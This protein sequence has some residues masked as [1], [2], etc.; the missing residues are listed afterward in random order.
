MPVTRE[1]VHLTRVEFASVVATERTE[2]T[3][4][5]IHDAAGVSADVELTSGDDTC[6]V[7]RLVTDATASL[8]G[9]PIASE[10]DVPAMLDLDEHRP[11]RDLALATAL[12]ALRTGASIIQAVKCGVSLTV[13]L[14]GQ[15][16]DS[17]PLYAN[18]NRGL[19]ATPRT[20]SDFAA[21]AERAVRGGF[22]AVKCAPFDE[23]GPEGG[24]DAVRLARPGIRRAAAVRDAVGPDVTL[25]VDCH[26]R[27]DIESAV[28]VAEELAEL[29]IDWFEE[30]VQ[31]TEDSAGLARIAARVPVVVAGGEKGYGEKLFADL[32]ARGAVE[33]I[34][35]DI[36]YCGGVAVAAR[37][38]IA[39]V[40][41][42][43]GVSLHSPS[44]PVSLLASGHVTAAMPG[45]MPLEH[46]VYEAD[47]RADLLTPPE[48]V[49]YGR[50]HV[51]AGLGLGAEL[52]W[53]LLRRMG[54][55]WRT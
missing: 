4:A 11:R 12:S 2:W 8:K 40:Q 34:M 27:F 6:E 14:G 28:I 46:A 7:V 47:W 43:G 16:R 22:R 23:V 52:N 45:A 13:A 17:V 44:G 50:L 39:A 15:Q 24:T 5:R 36:K 9:A 1:P 33:V 32:I 18:I 35:P 42:G 48:L 49:S 29:G 30:P 41:A 19:F 10:A 3:F 38:G 25:L 53:D 26:S 51:P 54:R 37:S 21:A 20:P 31:P 55:V